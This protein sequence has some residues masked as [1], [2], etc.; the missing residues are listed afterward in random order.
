LTPRRQ[1]IQLLPGGTALLAAL[2]FLRPG[3]LPDA[4]RP[5]VNTYPY[6]VLGVG[7]FLGWYFNRSRVVF[8]LLLL[9]LADA[10]LLRFGV[11]KSTG[12]GV[13]R[14]VFDALSVLL[15]L[16]LAAYA[17]LD[18]RGLLTI[19]G[20]RRLVLIPTQV[21][22]VLLIVLLDWQGPAAWLEH[23]FVDVRLTAWT[24]LPQTA[25]ATFGATGILLTGRCMLRSS[26]IEAGFL[27]T[28]VSTFVALHGIRLGWL[29]TNF[30]A[31]G[32][33]A[34]I[35]GLVET[36]YRMAY[37]DDLTELPGRRAMNEAL[38]QLGSRYA[39]AMVD[40]DH[41]KRFNDTYGHDVG[42]QVLRMVASR[43]GGVSGGGKAFRYGG[44]EFSVIFP[45]KSTEE[46]APHLEA[47]RRAVAAS[48][49]AVRSSGRPRKKPSTPKP[50]VASRKEVSVTVSIGV[51]DRD[52][53]ETDP[54]QVLKAADKALYRAKSAGRNRVM[55]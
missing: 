5:Y 2:V 11:G 28:L 15:P 10:A 47:L 16:N 21:V 20:L 41:F 43:L 38:L 32:G 18:E 26:A 49:F 30:L 42:D 53:R 35:G 14:T 22:A 55:F 7:V 33:L 54:Q 46:A 23:P 8:A 50:S 37:H 9:A 1:F 52:D 29:P 45:N 27:W 40:V 44:E 34:L 12:E 31:T 6:A 25:L 19:R 36:S 48:R 13:G 24:V 3:V 4:M 17:M 51:A 39:M